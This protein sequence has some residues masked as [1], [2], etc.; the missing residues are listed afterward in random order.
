VIATIRDGLAT[1]LSTISGLKVHDTV[2][3]DIVPPAA[4]VVPLT[5]AYDDTQSGTDLYRFSIV[6][7]AS[8]AHE[9]TGQNTLDAYIAPDGA[10]SV[11]AAVDGDPDLASTVHDTRVVS[12]DEYG[13]IVIA[14]V[15]YWGA[16]FTIEVYA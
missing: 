2:P 7:V 15:S 6:V 10:S 5:V 16:R 1:R 8:R 4:V 9:E 13:D 3:A 14:D 12:M 11:K